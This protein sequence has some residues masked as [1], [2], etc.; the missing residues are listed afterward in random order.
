MAA[1]PRLDTVVLVFNGSD[2]TAS[3]RAR[4]LRMRD[5]HVFSAVSCEREILPGKLAFFEQRSNG[6][7][8]TLGAGGAMVSVATYEP[9]AGCQFVEL[10]ESD[11]GQP[12][13]VPEP[14]MGH[15]SD[16]M[17]GVLRLVERF[18]GMCPFAA[19]CLDKTKA[20]SYSD[21]DMAAARDRGHRHLHRLE[22]SLRERVL[23]TL[24]EV[25]YQ[26]VCTQELRAN[27]ARK[28]RLI[29]GTLIALRDAAFDFF[30]NVVETIRK[31]PVQSIV[32][33]LLA[34]AGVVVMIFGGPV[35]PLGNALVVS[36]FAGFQRLYKY[37]A[38]PGEDWTKGN[39]AATLCRIGKG[40]CFTVVV[41]GLV[42]FL[43]P[44]AVGGI[45]SALP[46]VHLGSLG[47]GFLGTVAQAI[48]R[49][50]NHDLIADTIT[51]V[52]VQ[53][54]N[55][56]F[57]DT[58]REG[59]LVAL[60]KHVALAI[61]AGA[62]IG[63]V[64]GTGAGV[65][66]GLEDVAEIAASSLVRGAVPIAHTVAAA[67]ARASTATTADAIADALRAHLPEM[68]CA[69]AT[70]PLAALMDAFAGSYGLT[71]EMRVA[72]SDAVVNNR[73]LWELDAVRLVVHAPSDRHIIVE[74]LSKDS[75]RPVK[76]CK[77]SKRSSAVVVVP[78][79]ERAWSGTLT[80]LLKENR[81]L[82]EP[83]LREVIWPCAAG[84]LFIEPR[85]GSADLRLAAF[86]DPTGAITLV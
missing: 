60:A 20:T 83:V 63:I 32:A 50:V 67:G 3:V 85:V 62:A 22:T 13:S 65:V 2:A 45:A 54:A 86:M 58:Y 9:A 36:A 43:A 77:I 52:A 35:A 31:N 68:K 78:I 34:A 57:G 18:R 61:L 23:F 73:S 39:I 16:E 47:N 55:G 6:M 76:V 69:A 11:S 15:L 30:A 10:C 12:Y 70:N 49:H 48:A 29:L 38:G 51:N 74:V 8:L 44:I 64:A 21:A 71:D 84:H 27:A 72:R 40:F 66:E 26:T 25:A 59:G 42:A 4:V 81:W 53:T 24:I 56:N 17:L 28:E 14:S 5:R 41:S 82:S 79:D 19:L 1:P 33:A 37:R 7:N 80:I 46:A 75:A